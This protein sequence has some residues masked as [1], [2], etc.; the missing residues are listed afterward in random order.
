MIAPGTGERMRDVLVVGGG[1]LGWSAASALR[2]KIPALRITVLPLPPPADALAERLSSTLPSIVEFHRDIGMSD[3]DALLRA[4]C[5][6]RLGTEFQHW[7]GPLPSYVHA[8]DRY[9]QAF[10]TASFHIHW[11][12]L[13]QAGSTPPF[14]HYSPAAAMAPHR[15]PRWC[16]PG[17]I[18]SSRSSP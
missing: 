10:G 11:V 3:G 8:Y 1:L 16:R 17:S 7:D 9:G 13:A 18:T 2:R 14:D 15:S 5:G 4:N 6:F 12:R